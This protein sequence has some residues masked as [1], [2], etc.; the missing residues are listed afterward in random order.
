MRVAI[1]VGRC[2][3][4]A[5]VLLTSASFVS[6]EEIRIVTWNLEWFFDH[7][8]TDDSSNIG[9]EFAAPNAQEFRDR[10]EGFADAI[11]EID[12]TIVALQEVENA[13]VVQAIANDLLQH[14]GHSFKVAFVQGRDSHTGQDVA[15]L[16][17]D[18]IP[19]EATR[20]DFADFQ[21]D[22]DF[23]D[24]SK[25]LRVKLELGGEEVTLVVVHLITRVNDRKRQAK[26]LRAWT[27]DIVPDRNIVV[28]G[29]FNSGLR[30]NETFPE[31]EMGIIRGFGTPETTDDLFD[32]HLR[33]DS[34]DTHVSGR[35]LDRIL[36]SPSL[37]QSGGV[38][39]T[40]VEV[41]K[42]LAILGSQD[43]GGGVA[44]HLPSSEQDRSDHFPLIAT[45]TVNGGQPP[46][47]PEVTK[48]QLLEAIQGLEE[49]I[50]RLSGKVEELREA[51][52]DFP[53]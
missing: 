25:H 32:T 14:H 30:V 11:D 29:D 47:E 5:G 39:F 8:I 40:A 27:E 37:M 22:G 33:L 18:G 50:E 26:T 7:D 52:E 20:F 49:E 44:Y 4:V 45:F 2:C 51:V 23:K 35:Q 3:L 15:F 38:E 42:D 17:R 41:K 10:V 43:S 34:G 12:P 16:V 1:L 19:F 53:D 24:L 46:P 9:K 6:A 28:L 48:A 13:Q 21:G 31:S 36:L